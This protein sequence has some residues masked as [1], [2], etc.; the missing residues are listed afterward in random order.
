[1]PPD[2]SFIIV[3]WNSRADITKCLQSLIAFCT[4]IDV[5]IIVFD[6]ASTDGTADFV[7]AHFPQ[8]RLLPSPVNTGFARG[9]NLAAQAARGRYLLF[10]NP[11]TW[12]NADL[13]AALAQFL[14][15]H[16]QAG[17]C[18]PRF[19][20]PD[21]SLQ[22]GA[23]RTLPT[24]ATLFYDLSGAARL[25]PRSRRCGGYLM[26]WWDH[27]DSRE[28][29]QPAGACFAIRREVFAQIG[30]FDEGYFMYYE[31]VELCRAILA[32]EWK[33]YFLHEACV[34]HVGGQSTSQA[35]PQ[36][37]P[38]F[39]RSLYRYFR[40]HHGRRAAWIAKFMIGLAEL[41]KLVAFLPLLPFEKFLPRPQF[42]RN[43]REQFARH[44]RFLLQHWFY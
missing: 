31:D 8:V 25:F 13:A 35:V 3:T 18:A 22:R 40:R 28:I 39:Y 17:A 10:L 21:G 7:A 41:G 14:D 32:A 5:E 6:N 37:F 9:N 30:G 16:P 11:D 12:V 4:G 19:L 33:I 15:A 27:N 23:I 44:G 29:E 38:E 36:N 26:T 1:M 43:R 34:Y 20:N 2:L 24:L 42:W